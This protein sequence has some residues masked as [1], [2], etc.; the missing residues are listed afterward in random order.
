MA[1]STPEDIELAISK[2]AVTRLS[3]DRAQAPNDAVVARAIADA[4][5]LIDSYVSTGGYVVP[6]PSD[7]GPVPI[8]KC[9]VDIAVYNLYARNAEEMGTENVR[10]RNYENAIAFLQ[11]IA[12]GSA[13]LNAEMVTSEST[14]AIR[15]VA[16]KRIFPK[17]IHK[18]MP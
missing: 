4:D 6:F 7:S 14:G 3:D 1:Y 18:Y 10:R 11:K 2:V 17:D 15:F 5:A 12:E 13:R 8:R 9:S 16:G